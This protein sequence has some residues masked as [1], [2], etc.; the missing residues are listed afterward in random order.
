MSE[1]RKRGNETWN[2]LLAWSEAQLAAERLAG[3]I[4]LSEGYVSVDP[5]HPLGGPDG[6]KDLTCFKDGEKW[7]VAVFFSRGKQNFSKIKSKFTSDIS[8]GRNEKDTDFIFFVNQ[9]L[10]LGERAKL[11]NDFASLGG[12][13]LE[14]YHLER[15]SLIMDQ[16]RN[17]PLR[18]DFL[19]IE[20]TKEELVAFISELESRLRTNIIDAMVPA[21][22]SIIKE[23][24][25]TS[26]VD[27]LRKD[28]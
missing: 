8:K 12:E 22:G 28:V 16:P 27:S 25:D 24:L 18:A 23:M 3:Q 13:N 9:Y 1:R 20:I 17:Y 6:G 15:I 10:T 26:Y 21:I 5:S 4:L 2:R 19:D 11:M 14:I 7:R